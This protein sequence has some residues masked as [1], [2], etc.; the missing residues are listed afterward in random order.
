VV[1]DPEPSA[2]RA[3][4]KYVNDDDPGICRV[5]RG[6]GFRYLDPRGKVVKSPSSIAGDPAR[7]DGYL[8]L[9]RSGRPHPG[10]RP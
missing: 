5:P 6:K 10:D 8:D 1:A 4:L 7:V 3:G 2:R 9:R